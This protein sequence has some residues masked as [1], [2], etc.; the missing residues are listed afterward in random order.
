MLLDCSPTTIHCFALTATGNMTSSGLSATS[1]AASATASASTPPATATRGKTLVSLRRVSLTSAQQQT[2]H[3]STKDAA[4]AA[5]GA[6]D[7]SNTDD[8]S[9]SGN[10][11][12]G[13]SSGGSSSGSSSSS[14]GSLRT[15]ASSN[16]TQSSEENRT[17]T[18]ADIPLEEGYPT[19]HALFADA[20]SVEQFAAAWKLVDAANK[21]CKLMLHTVRSSKQDAGADETLWEARVDKHEVA[22]WYAVM[23]RA[24]CDPELHLGL[25]QQRLEEAYYATLAEFR[26]DVS[27]VFSNSIKYNTASIG[28]QRSQQLRAAAIQ[29][30]LVFETEYDKTLQQ[31][32]E[33]FAGS[34]ALKRA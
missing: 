25:V 2:V 12:S 3:C 23:L 22:D 14:G 29:L 21:R 24:Q 27:A 5:A 33:Q 18:A 17:L 11:S 16:T 20:Q 32:Q 6:V 8:S 26:C 9:S 4:A 15:W 34:V 31:L 7:L 19:R 13:S 30:L 10:S 1:T 28:K